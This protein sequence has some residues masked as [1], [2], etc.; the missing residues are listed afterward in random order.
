MA[1]SNYRKNVGK[2]KVTNDFKV[3]LLKTGGMVVHGKNKKKK[4]LAGQLCYWFNNVYFPWKM[5]LAKDKRKFL[6][7]YGF[8][9]HTASP[10][11]CRDIALS[12]SSLGT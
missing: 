2:G 11:F 1:A 6:N 3:S 12:I 10:G 5:S 9:A 4:A 7:S 8:L